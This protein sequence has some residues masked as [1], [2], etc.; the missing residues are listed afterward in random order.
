MWE[1]LLFFCWKGKSL[2]VAQLHWNLDDR[3]QD[4]SLGECIYVVWCWSQKQCECRDTRMWTLCS[5][6]CEM[7][8]II[9]P[10]AGEISPTVSRKLTATE[11]VTFSSSLCVC[12]CVFV[13]VSTVYP[14]C[15]SMWMNCL[16][17]TKS[18]WL[19]VNALS[20][21]HWGLKLN[22]SECA[23]VRLGVHTCTHTC[24]TVCVARLHA[25]Q[26]SCWAPRPG[27]I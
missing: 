10:L 18:V 16:H 5:G 7:A 13:E 27:Y 22:K 21:L 1:F 20:F 25:D 6:V 4:C 9:T 12:V 19:V 3:N 17:T 24:S 23:C 15:L 14:L 2:E 26:A 8:A 11:Q